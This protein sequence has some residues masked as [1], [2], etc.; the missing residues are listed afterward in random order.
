[1]TYENLLKSLIEKNNNIILLTAENKAALRNI[2]PQ[3]PNNFIDVG[4]AEQSLV[5]ISA[6]L[7]LTGKKPI[8]HALSA[9]LTMR[10]FEFIRTDVG[11]AN[12]PIKL[13]GSFAGFLS[14]ANG[15][16]HQAVED[17]ALMRTIPNMHIVTPA[18]NDELLK[19]IP[20]C[21]NSSNPAYIRFNN[22][23]TLVNHSNLPYGKA[24]VFEFGNDVTII[25]YGLMFSNA[26]EALKLLKDKNIYATLINLRTI[27]PL[28]V[29]TLISSFI[30]T[31]LIVAIED[32][33]IFGGLY[34]LLLEFAAK[35]NFKNK[36]YPI[37]LKNKFFKPAMLNNVFEHEGF[38][39]A[40][41]ANT[42]EQ[43]LIKERDKFYAEWSTLQ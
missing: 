14:E 26:Y 3:I 37:A 36:I 28:D 25:T 41:L 5:G 6:G 15:P 19:I 33:Y 40:A 7:A 21:L 13:V 12:L 22:L 29:D 11:A 24:E 39:P 18:D 38:T 2:T 17:I 43:F 30:N 16:T 35:H 42:I 27:N 31:Q 1:M 23:P 34:S 8:A 10:A 32:H 4:I 20:K 9:F